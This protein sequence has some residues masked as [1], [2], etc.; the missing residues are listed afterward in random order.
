MDQSKIQ[1]KGELND[2]DPTLIATWK[3]TVDIS[4]EDVSE[5]TARERQMLVKLVARMR[6]DELWNTGQVGR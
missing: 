2:I 6:G 4:Q 5:K 1:H 3:Q